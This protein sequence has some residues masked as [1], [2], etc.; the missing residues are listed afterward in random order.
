MAAGHQPLEY[1]P[2]GRILLHFATCPVVKVINGQH[3][4]CCDTFKWF[5]NVG[6]GW[7][8]TTQAEN[9]GVPFLTALVDLLWEI[10]DQW[11][12]LARRECHKPEEVWEYS[13]NRRVRGHK[14]QRVLDVAKL[15]SKVCALADFQLHTWWEAASNW[16]GRWAN[17]SADCR[18]KCQRGGHQPHVR[19]TCEKFVVLP[20]GT[21][22]GLRMLRVAGGI[23]HQ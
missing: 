6:L 21:G 7:L 17:V 10:T 2:S 18:A 13:Q 9:I 3:Q 16:S 5:Q 11:D 15:E 14:S 20:D 19:R 8:N 22:R 1:D 12:T 23:R 4:L